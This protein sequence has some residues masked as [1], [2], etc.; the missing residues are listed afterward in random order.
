MRVVDPGVRVYQASSSEIFGATTDSPQHE[1]T[2]C[3][4]HTPYG[5]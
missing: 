1:S 3:L 2:R 5:V 4:P